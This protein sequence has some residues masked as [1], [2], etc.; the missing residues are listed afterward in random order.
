MNRENVLIVLGVLIG[1]SPYL[2]VPLSM[3]GIVLPVLGLLVIAI[4]LMLRRTNQL[5]LRH[6]TSEHTLPIHE[7]PEA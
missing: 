7:S 2:G 6:A 1:I 5:S 3:L 4:G